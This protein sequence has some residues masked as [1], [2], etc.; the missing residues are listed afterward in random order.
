M[1]VEFLVVVGQGWLLLLVS[2]TIGVETSSACV[3]SYELSK[4]SVISNHPSRSSY[5]E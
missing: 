2:S 5:L 1:A 4:L 3:G